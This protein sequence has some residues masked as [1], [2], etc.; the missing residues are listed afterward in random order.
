M[1][2]VQLTAGICKLFAESAEKKIEFEVR[3]L[4]LQVLSIKRIPSSANA[5][6]D[7]YRMILSDGEHF[8]QAM[9]ATNLNHTVTESQVSKH[10]II[11][12]DSFSTSIVQERQYVRLCN[13]SPPTADMSKV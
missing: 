4:T 6:T 13:L 3:P 8:L 7:R 9:L 11:R 10:S 1:S 5:Q 12:V 2:N